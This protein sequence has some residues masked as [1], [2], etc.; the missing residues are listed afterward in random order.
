M[1]APET[2]KLSASYNR[3]H[4]LSIQLLTLLRDDSVPVIYG[5]AACGLTMG[6]LSR[7]TD[8]LSPEEE[9]QF[10]QDIVEWAGAYWSRLEGVN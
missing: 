6:R 7:P 2:G 5:M 3:V 10:T 4:D 9:I 1:L 8:V